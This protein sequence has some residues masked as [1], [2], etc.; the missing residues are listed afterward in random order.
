MPRGRSFP[1]ASFLLALLFLAACSTTQVPAP[2]ADPELDLQSG[3]TLV[4]A[5]YAMD[6]WSGNS[7]TA[8]LVASNFT[9]SALSAPSGSN[10]DRFARFDHTGYPTSP[11]LQ[12]SGHAADALAAYTKGRF[13][14]FTVTG[15]LNLQALHLKV[16][17]GTSQ[18]ENGFS[19]R[20][21]V[22]N[23]ASVL[24]DVP[25]VPTERPNLTSYRVDLSGAKFQGLQRIV[26][27]IYVH[28]N[29]TRR[30]LEFDDI[31]LNAVAP[32]ITSTVPA[33]P[34]TVRGNTSFTT[35]ALTSEQRLWY[36]RLW[37][38]I[39]NPNQEPSMNSRAS[40]D[41]IYHYA[42][43]LH[44]H[45][46]TLLTVFRVTGDLR[47][48]DEVDRLA[49]IM[50][51]KLHDSWRG[52]ID[53]TDG[54]QD[55]FL[56]WVERHETTASLAGKDLTEVNEMRTHAHV[57]MLAYAFHVNRDLV[58][59]SGVNYGA[60]ADFWRGYLVNHFE[61]KWRKRKN[62]PW[63]QF[64]FLERNGMP[65]QMDW[66]KYHYYMG[67]LTGKSEYTR[68]ARRL[69][70][71][72]FTC[73]FRTASSPNGTAYVWHAS[74]ACA[75]GG[76][77]DYLQPTTYGRYI[78]AN[79][80][81]L[82]LEGFYTWADPVH[83]PRFANTLGQFIMDNGATD[84][85]RDMGGGIARAGIAAS[86]EEE[87]RRQNPNNYD[88]MPYVL[89]APWDTSGKVASIS[90]QVY[91]NRNSSSLENPRRTFLPAGLF[92]NLMYKR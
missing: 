45:T 32:T 13:F 72:M 85:A 19:V 17:K 23:Y 66:I 9:A 36:D 4:L 21:S 37:A 55:G 14:E 29:N 57:A 7:V 24:L 86:P 59:P 8:N 1:L 56:N 34:Y 47:L 65:S 10:L 31:S 79:A 38:G 2:E 41:N 75:N 20:T 81:E 54:T 52:T 88:F 62:K 27:R 74:R 78:I 84:F 90:T 3:T 11:V 69:T 43:D 67:L 89:I 39:R 63:P 22:D 53:G 25:N 15:S 16:A 6:R 73:E 92:F 58:S 30:L 87:W 91:N 28:T 42:R 60:R 18:G 82:H 51:G 12:T 44:T 61:A 46:Q 26:V 48:L 71:E 77:R 68:E 64:P 83:M 70:D 49:Q 50:R 5:Q 35:S 40:S 33:N 76:E 80:V